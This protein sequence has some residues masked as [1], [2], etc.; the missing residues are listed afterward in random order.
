MPETGE[1]LWGTNGDALFVPANVV[2]QFQNAGHDSMEATMFSATN[3][4]VT[5][6]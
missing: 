5:Y 2:H 6:Y 3:E 1:S 4:G